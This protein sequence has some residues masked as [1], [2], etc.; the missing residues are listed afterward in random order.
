MAITTENFAAE[1]EQLKQDWAAMPE[2]EQRRQWDAY[3][4]AIDHGEAGYHRYHLVL[5]PLFDGGLPD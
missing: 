2:G 1:W 4:D 3:T 5:A